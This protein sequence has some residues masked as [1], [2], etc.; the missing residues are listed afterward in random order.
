MRRRMLLLLLVLLLGLLTG[1]SSPIR[2]VTAQ[3]D[4]QVNWWVFAGGG[5]SSGG[6]DVLVSTTLGQA[7]SG[8]SQGGV[9]ELY[10]G[11]WHPGLGP[12]SVEI[13]CFEAVWRAEGVL[14]TWKTAQEIDLLGFN[15]YCAPSE[16][17]P[18]VQINPE[19]IP[20]QYIGQPEG[21]MYTWLD[22]GVTPGET[23]YYT[24]EALDINERG[25]FTDAVR[26]FY[27]VHLPL[28]QQ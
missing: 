17:G 15:L 23:Y 7:V 16:S 5:G 8:S 24:L 22:E 6:E 18:W 13:T 3:G 27:Q 26:V 14:V 12:T 9:T 11:Y 2:K 1:S 21:G 28:I 4:T 10:A 25:S 20:N 19:L